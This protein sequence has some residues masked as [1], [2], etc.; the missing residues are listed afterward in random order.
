MIIT[1]ASVAV[2]WYVSEIYTAEAEKLL[3]T[4]YEIH[5]PELILPEDSAA[6]SG[7]PPAGA[8]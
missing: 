4:S 6:S 7:E 3:D 8:I 2:K 5:A 1:D